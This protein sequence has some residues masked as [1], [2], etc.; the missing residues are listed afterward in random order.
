MPRSCVR[1]ACLLQGGPDRSGPRTNRLCRQLPLIKSLPQQSL[2]DRVSFIDS[3]NGFDTFI[4]AALQSKHVQLKVVSSVDKADYVMDSS[5]FHTDEFVATPKFASTGRTPDPPW[6]GQQLKF[7]ARHAIRRFAEVYLDS[8]L[9]T[10]M[11]RDPKGIY[12][13]A[14][15][16][17]SASVP[18]LQSVYE[19]P[20]AA[21][22]V[23]RGGQESPEIAA[24]RVIAVL[25]EK[26]Y[27]PACGT[28]QPQ[29]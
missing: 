2:L 25:V 1:E 24:H 5:L 4:L 18:G 10:C 26:G 14:L 6:L 16:G 22:V 29:A 23:V 8:P 15:E 19:P 27:V 17:A 13:Q 20:Q 21:E 11:A 28:R 7:R 12:H 9:A 3:N